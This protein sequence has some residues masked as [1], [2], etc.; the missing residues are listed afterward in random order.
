MRHPWLRERAEPPSLAEQ[1]SSLSEESRKD[2][3]PSPL[4]R[5]RSNVSRDELE[6]SGTLAAMSLG[7][8]SGLGLGAGER[9]EGRSAEGQG[10]GQGASPTAIR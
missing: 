7:G 4:E 3:R 5:S 9:S 10:Q 1:P 8:L 2:E 6:L